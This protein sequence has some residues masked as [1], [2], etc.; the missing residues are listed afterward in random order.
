MDE[1]GTPFCVTIDGETMKDQTLTVRE[2]DAMTQE[3]VSL[4]KIKGYLLERLSAE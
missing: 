2:R 1:I 3:R 4:D